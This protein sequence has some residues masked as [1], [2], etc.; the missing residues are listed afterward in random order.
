MAAQNAAEGVAPLRMLAL[1]AAPLVA[2][3]GNDLIPITI[4]PAQQE[5]DALNDAC[6]KLGVALEIQVEIATTERI[7]EILETIRQPFDILHFIGH[8]SQKQDGS[9]VL[10]LEGETGM[11]RLLDVAELQR[12]IGS[13][14][15]ARLAFL[16]ACH[17]EGL[18]KAL[19]ATGV[20]HVIAINA[21]DAVLDLAARV[22][23]RRFYAALLAG[24]AVAEAFDAGTRAVA[25]NDELRE[26]R[27]PET[28]Q[29]CN[30]LE[31]LKFCLLP[32]GDPIHQQPLAPEP[33]RGAVRF[34]RALWERTN[35]SEASADPF[36]GRARE[37]HRIAME[38][39][40]DDCRCVAI[41]GMGGMGKTALALAAA[42]WQRE[43]DR[44]RDGVWW[45][46]LRNVTGAYEARS[47][48]A[49]TLG[50]EAKTAESDTALTTALRDRHL[51]L[52]LDDLDALLTQDKDG[53]TA[54]L[55]ALLDVRRLKLLTT[56]RRDLPGQVAHQAIELRRLDPHDA[57]TVFRIYA[58]PIEEWG[59]WQDTD[60]R[61]LNRFLDGYPFPI[62]LAATA[63]KQ[64]R[65]SLRDLLGRLQANP[66]GT[67]R[68]PGD[69]E[70]RETSLAATLDLSYNLLP[71]PARRIFAELAIFPAGLTR[72]AA[73]AILGA[74]S[75]TALETLARH[76]MAEY[77]D[78]DERFT[79]P[80]PARRYA[81]GRQPPDALATC[82]P[83]ALAYFADLIAAADSAI[84]RGQIVE[85][86]KALTREQPNIAHVLDWG[87]DHEDDTGGISRAARAT[88][89]LRNYW[90]LMDERGQPETL[91]RLRRAL[92]AAQRIGDR[93]GEAD[94][95]LAIGDVQ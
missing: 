32:E 42:R 5:L 72:K 57:Q 6:G 37:L 22:F 74:E 54:L 86:R 30:L 46:A 60:W 15:P 38:L 50:L 83:A 36:V 76:S 39:R 44:W 48:I 24:R 28:L 79:L 85:G 11:L 4:L 3:R 70:D 18:A 61:D 73:R 25:T 26:W 81:E 69:D 52:A 41:H 78:S 67:F 19:L 56:A 59:K 1:I 87:Y 51:L 2:K 47:R 8:G 29:P 64:G 34:C 88:A 89:Q 35:L 94:V 12:L 7:G 93:L 63:M 80:E 40:K 31:E 91:A 16:S 53:T 23:A 27:D 82:A 14:R 49:Q 92:A 9:S 65:W 71:E 90:T 95:L 66:Q 10:A 58:P 75:E 20:T 68:Y 62:R 43:R 55:R 84:T 13:R 21:A 17:S 77:R 45:V 33:P